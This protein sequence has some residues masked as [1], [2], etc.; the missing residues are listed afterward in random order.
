MKMIKRCPSGC[1]FF[2][3]YD[4]QPSEEQDSR[5]KG[6]D[7]PA[8]K[9]LAAAVRVLVEVRMGY[10]TELIVLDIVLIISH[11]LWMLRCMP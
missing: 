2:L 7:D 11:F 3:L 9:A 6:Y 5:G 1:R 10:H 4:E 8:G